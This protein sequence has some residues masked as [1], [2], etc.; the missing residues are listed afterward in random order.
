MDIEFIDA[1]REE[2]GVVT[3]VTFKN[4]PSQ[5]VYAVIDAPPGVTPRQ[6]KNDVEAVGIMRRDA[7]GLKIS[8]THG[9]LRVEEVLQ[10]E[11]TANNAQW[12]RGILREIGD[13]ELTIEEDGGNTRKL[14]LTG[15]ETGTRAWHNK[16][17]REEFA[18]GAEIHYKLTDSD[19]I[20]TIR[21]PR[22][23]IGQFG[24]DALAWKGLTIDMVIDLVAPEVTMFRREEINVELTPDGWEVTGRST[25]D[26]TDIIEFTTRDGVMDFATG[27]H[28]LHIG[29]TGITSW[30]G[31]YPETVQMAMTGQPLSKFIKLPFPH[32]DPRIS[33]IKCF[34][35]LEESA[36][37]EV[38]TPMRDM[39][40]S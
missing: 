10:F 1:V 9:D 36:N 7:T 27:T 24:I 18:I 19:I 33:K 25:L 2:D 11:W 28:E 16:R 35:S 32:H 5:K 40:R 20:G 4:M 13:C 30:K 3:V 12:I 8:T 26:N 23:I 14:T 31:S 29:A 6:L 34:H 21:H 37:I 17:V 38:D 22:P 15:N 39:V